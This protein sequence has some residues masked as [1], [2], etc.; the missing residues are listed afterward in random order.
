MERG[1]TVVLLHGLAAGRLNMH[2]IARVLRAGGY[3]TLNLAYPS[4]GRSL[5]RIVDSLAEEIAAGASG[6]IHFV[7]HSMGGLVARALIARHR[8]AQ[9]GRVVMLGPP[10]QGS[11]WVSLLAQM[12]L[13]RPLLREAR[14][15]LTPNRN[16]D[17]VRKLAMVDYPL[18]IIAGDRP[19][20]PLLPRL[21]LPGPNDGKV[22]VAATRLA[23]AA[24]HIVLSVPHT[25]MVISRS[26]H[27]QVIAFLRHG[28]FNR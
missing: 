18:G 4:R 14:H 24:D 22:S 1:D 9:L 3:R 25:L 5:D 20:D 6:T 21:V 8:P 15:L 16:D 27:R 12:R 17:I 23:G 10:N 26:V 11:E 7:T 2:P 19:L 28:R 13:D